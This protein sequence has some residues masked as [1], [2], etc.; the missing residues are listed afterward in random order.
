[1]SLTVVSV[2]LFWIWWDVDTIAAQAKETNKK[3]ERIAEAL[4][5][6]E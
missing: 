2:L 4:E 6:D 5:A 3:L 1:M